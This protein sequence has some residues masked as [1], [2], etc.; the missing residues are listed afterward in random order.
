M[1][2]IIWAGTVLTASQADPRNNYAVVIEENKIIDSGSKQEM[3]LRYPGADVFGD[4]HYLM[5]PAFV[6]SHDHGRALGTV[7]LGVADDLLEIWLPGLW[8]QPA[9][10]C[11]SAAVYDG[12]QLLKAGVTTVS[13][14][15]NPR[16]WD[17]MY[18]EAKKTIQGYQD[19]GI[20]VVFNPAFINQNQLVYED[21]NAFINSL[22]STIQ[23]LAKPFAVSDQIDPDTYIETCTRLFTAFH[24]EQ[25][26]LV[27]INV[28]PVGGQ[29]VSDDMLLRLTQL[30]RELNTRLQMH[31]LETPFHKVYAQRKWKKSY[32]KHLEEIGFLGPWLTLAHMVYVDHEDLPVLANQ[33][34]GIA[35]NPSSNLRLRSGIAP[36]AAM[37]QHGIPVGLGLDGAALDDD[38]DFLREMRLAWFLANKPGAKT[39]TLTSSDM[40]KIGID[41]GVKITLGEDVPLGKLEPG[42]LADL[43]L[44]DYDALQG[45]W[46]LPGSN[47]ADVL[48]HKGTRSHVKHVMVNGEWS[49]RDGESAK[50]N[51]AVVITIIREQLNEQMK[52]PAQKEFAHSAKL[53]EPYIR[54]YYGEWA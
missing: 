32:V 51:E 41:N 13:H 22:P 30:A 31:L 44:L 28:N 42:Y 53:L 14:H 1:T 8:V 18:E 4:S 16:S 5:T 11:Y 23:E 20:R 34:T 39:P 15:H 10:D 47:P 9:I 48:L 7:P 25:E 17:A 45:T 40:L 19:T 46:Y 36:L 21:A 3:L 49:L 50:V 38:Q 12:I 33:Q 29:W 2:L 26:H 24:D 43:V 52:N 54:K 27:K 37:V 35:S 6:D